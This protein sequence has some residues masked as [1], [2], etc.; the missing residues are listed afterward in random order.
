VNQNG[1]KTMFQSLLVPL[2]RST[3]AEHALPPAA[4][5]ARRAGA[6][7]ELVQVHELYA[8]ADPAAN[9]SPYSPTED[10]EWR[11]KER[12]Y[13]T[14]TANWVNAVARVEATTAVVSGEVAEAILAQSWAGQ[15]DLIVMAT[16]GRGRVS[17]FFVGSVADEVLRGATA[18]VLVVRG[19]DAQPSLFPEPVLGNFL[20]PLDGSPL[21]EQILPAALDL[22]RLMG[23]RCTLLRVADGGEGTRAEAE[24]YLARV[25]SRLGAEGVEIRTRVLVAPSP[26]EVILDVA[27]AQRHDLVALATHGRGGIRRLLF[28][29]V[30]DEVVRGLSVPV[31]VH[32][33]TGG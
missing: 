7:L 25:A 28:G 22:A 17:R 21:A 1:R 18:S 30:A 26:A 31:L 13:L 23:A 27:R 10:A 14:A 24:G 3:F 19:G 20:I 33:P 9:W 4:S 11:E 6:R 5:I 8:L 16:H 32:R 29:S 12:L 2:D 15:A